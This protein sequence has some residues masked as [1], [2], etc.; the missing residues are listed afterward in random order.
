MLDYTK[1]T[2]HMPHK[3][4]NNENPFGMVPAALIN[5]PRIYESFIFIR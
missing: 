1:N 5:K 4:V 3:S 2:K